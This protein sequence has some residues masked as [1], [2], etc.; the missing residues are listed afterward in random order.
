MQI[1]NLAN[2]VILCFVVFFAGET[3]GTN[4][5][6][7]KI[8]N[9]IGHFCFSRTYEHSNVT[10]TAPVY[11]G[12]GIRHT[13][14]AL[15][16]V[17]CRYINLLCTCTYN[18]D[19]TVSLKVNFVQSLPVVTQCRYNVPYKYGTCTTSITVLMYW[20]LVVRVPVPVTQIP[21]RNS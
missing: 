17:L 14:H 12:T 20:V 19:S 13:V 5:E 3:S 7:K 11:T 4:P 9:K 10:S 1:L 15:Y 21:T 2:N 18:G 6:N 16:A 8:I